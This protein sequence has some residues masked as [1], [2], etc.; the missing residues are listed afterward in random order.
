MYQKCWN[1]SEGHR[2]GRSRGE[3]TSVGGGQSGQNLLE[4]D[5]THLRL[6][7]LHVGPNS[8]RFGGQAFM[9]Y[10]IIEFIQD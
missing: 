8:D 5:G 2:S 3:Y 9:E 1:A 6:L 4:L 7:L 10:Y